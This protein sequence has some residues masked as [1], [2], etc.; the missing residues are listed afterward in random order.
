VAPGGI[1]NA[2][3]LSGGGASQIFAKP[4]WQAGPGVPGDAMRDI[5]DVAMIAGSPGVT[6]GADVAGS[7]Q[8]QCCWGGTSLSA[9]LW[10]GYSRTIAQQQGAARLGLLNPTIYRLAQNGLL[11]NGIE[12]VTSGNNNFNGVPGFSAGAGYDLVTGWGSADM[13]EFASAYNGTPSPTPTPA[14]HRVR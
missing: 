13:T 3:G 2:W 6:I 1:E 9:P 10:A 4:E 5:P 11:A 14:L 12:D 8:L 7:A